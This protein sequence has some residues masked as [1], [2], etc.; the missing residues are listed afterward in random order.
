MGSHYVSPKGRR[1]LAAREELVSKLRS[2][3]K[4]KNKSLYGI[5]NE[6]LEQAIRL[7]SLGE[8]LPDIINNYRIIK[9]AKENRSVL[10][11]EKIWY[12]TLEKAFQK[13][14]DSFKETFYDSGLWYGKYFST[15]LTDTHSLEGIKSAL[16]TIFWNASSLEI[17]QNGDKIILRYIEPNFTDSHTQFLSTMLEGIMH[18]LGYLIDGKKIARGLVMLTFTKNALE[19]EEDVFKER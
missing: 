9:M 10:I 8:E 4:A 7:N 2:I 13:T 14:D 11:P 19:R 3:A 6:I 12:Q 15:V 17:T 5:T 1:F 18:S 16:Q